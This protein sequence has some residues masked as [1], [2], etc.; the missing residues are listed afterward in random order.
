M[1]VEGELI[2]RMGDFVRKLPLHSFPAVIIFRYNAWQPCVVKNIHSG[3]SA[4][5]H[6]HAHRDMVVALGRIGPG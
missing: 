4:H 1:V 3:I 5:K 6:M 2:Y